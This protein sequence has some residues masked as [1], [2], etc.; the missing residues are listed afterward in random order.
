MY[1]FLD[2]RYAL[3]LYD[4]CIEKGNVEQVLYEFK[5]IIEDMM[6]NEDLMKLIKHPHISKSAKIRIF[7]EIFGGKITDEL[8]NFLIL[9]VERERILFLKEKYEQFRL[10]HLERTNTVIAKVKTVVPLDDDQKT[11]LKDKLEK[12]YEKTVIV[13]EEIDK[14]LIGGIVIRVGSDIIDGSI[15]NKLKEM[16]NIVENDN[17]V[18]KNL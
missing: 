13:E 8:L 7:K 4:T 15:K 3:A 14:S 12:L 10:I 11:A 16:K 1:E 18:R 5:T 2:R 6:N 9:L 17:L